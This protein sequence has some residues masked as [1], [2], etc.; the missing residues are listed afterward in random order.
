MWERGTCEPR[1]GT[2]RS[3]VLLTRRSADWFLDAE[4]PA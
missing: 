4:Q 2:L 1:V 3:M